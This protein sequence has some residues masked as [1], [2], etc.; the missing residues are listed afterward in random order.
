MSDLPPLPLTG[1]DQELALL[2]A[3]LE[4][5]REGSGQAIGLRG[6]TGIGKSRLLQAVKER[7]NKLGLVTVRGHAYR[8]DKGVPYGLW[9]DAF[10]P[11][12]RDMDDS[13]LSVLTRGGEAG[14]GE[15]SARPR[16]RGCP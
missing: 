7:A 2:S 12:L 14:A 6:E 8:T 5:A 3:A 13:T 10:L 11:A 15:G 4:S 9:S 16:G 1:R